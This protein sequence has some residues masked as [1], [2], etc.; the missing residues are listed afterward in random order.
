MN[1]LSSKI[2]IVRIIKSHIST[3]GNLNKLNKAD[4][5]TFY[6]FLCAISILTSKDR[7]IL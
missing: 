6:V 2:N 5:W 7:N 3:L 4:T 1:L